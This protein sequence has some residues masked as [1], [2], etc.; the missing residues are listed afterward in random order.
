MKPHPEHWQQLSILNLL[1]W[2]SVGVKYPEFDLSQSHGKQATTEDLFY[3][4]A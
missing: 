2:L 1:P 3:D 4:L